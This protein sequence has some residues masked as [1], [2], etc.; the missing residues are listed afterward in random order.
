M[1]GYSCSFTVFF[2]YF[3]VK[4]KIMCTRSFIAAIFVILLPFVARATG[5]YGDRIVVDGE[6]WELLAKP[7]ERDSLLSARVRAAL[8]E[9]RERTTANWSGYIAHWE[10]KNGLL[11]LRKIE[12]EMGGKDD[13]SV[14]LAPEVMKDIFASYVEPDGICARWFSW[15]KTRMGRGAVVKYYHMGFNRNYETEC[16]MKI[17]KGEVK[18]RALYHNGRTAGMDFS[19]AKEEFAKRFPWKRFPELEGKH[20]DFYVWKTKVSDDNRVVAIDSVCVYYDRGEKISDQKHPLVKAL[21]KTMM[22]LDPVMVYRINGDVFPVYES[23]IFTVSPEA[24]GE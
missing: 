19:E 8:P 22:A 7:I 11:Y 3:A 23:K 2:V 15:T 10:L 13:R 21:K 18:D 1:H 12:V 6:E 4:M 16:V 5:Q 17:E 24:R 20:F 9:D 14:T